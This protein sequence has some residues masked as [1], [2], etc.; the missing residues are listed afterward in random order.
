MQVTLISLESYKK[1]SSRIE[2]QLGE[3]GKDGFSG[4]G[5]RRFVVVSSLFSAGL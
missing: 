3:R 5:C 4:A 2:L 1:R